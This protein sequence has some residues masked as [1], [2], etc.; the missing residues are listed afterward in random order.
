M[1][2]EVNAALAG[3]FGVPVVLGSGDDAA[4]AELGAL[5]PE[6][7]TVDLATLVPGVSRA[8]GGRTVTF[9]GRDILE[10]YRLIQLVVQLGQI[11]PG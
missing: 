6:A 2:A 9:T 11:K 1:T 4:C 10:A 3:H 8:P 5:V 7:V